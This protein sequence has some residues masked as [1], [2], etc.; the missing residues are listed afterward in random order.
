MAELA[1][2][3][4]VQESLMGLT[5]WRPT[6]VTAAPDHRHHILRTLSLPDSIG[7]AA[8]YAAR[9]VCWSSSAILSPSARTS[10]WLTLTVSGLAM[11]MMMFIMASGLTLVFGLMDIIN[12]GHGAFISLGAFMS[13]FPCCLAARR[14]DRR[15]LPAA[16]YRGDAAAMI[17]AMLRHGG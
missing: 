15:G 5:R 17:A 2:D 13:A 1:G 16:Q 10:S 3:T 12:F 4:S 8:P 14:L 9:A 11:G 7:Q 6:D